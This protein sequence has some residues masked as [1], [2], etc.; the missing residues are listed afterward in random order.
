MHEFLRIYIQIQEKKNQ[1]NYLNSSF[2]WS[3]VIFCVK[4]AS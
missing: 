4:L 1:T 2:L 3:R